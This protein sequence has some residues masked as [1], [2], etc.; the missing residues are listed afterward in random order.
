VRSSVCKRNSDI[1]AANGM[2]ERTRK[3]RSQVR[4]L[5]HITSLRR[6]ADERIGVMAVVIHLISKDATTGHVT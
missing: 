6:N 2:V 4:P 3:V 5:P 1:T